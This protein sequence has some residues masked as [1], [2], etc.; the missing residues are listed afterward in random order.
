MGRGEVGRDR[1][2]R[3]GAVRQEHRGRGAGVRGC[4]GARWGAVGYGVGCCRRTLLVSCC[5]ASAR[6]HGEE[7]SAEG[8][9]RTSSKKMRS[10]AR[11]ESS[12]M[13]LSS[14][15]CFSFT[16]LAAA[17]LRA[18]SF[19]NARAASAAAFSSASFRARSSST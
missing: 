8:S 6:F 3:G 19:A 18:S 2:E 9:L 10:L 14:L 12:S 16:A 17:A 11:R 7:E 1:S 13:I 15:A 5:S 4:G